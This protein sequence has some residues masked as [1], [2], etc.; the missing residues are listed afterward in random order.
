MFSIDRFSRAITDYAWLVIIATLALSFLATYGITKLR[1]TNDYR[2][3]F[4]DKN[5]YLEAFEELERTYSS[6]DTILFVY[7]PN[8]GKATS[9]EALRLA[10]DI[11]EASWQIPYS[12]RVDSV[13]N[14]QNTRAIGM[15]DLEVRAIVPYKED[16]NPESSIYAEDTI[17]GEP[18]LAGRLLSKDARTAAVIV[19]ATPPRDDATATTHIVE[20]AR[21]IKAEM[22]EKY[23]DFRIELTGSQL[24]SNSFSEA[25]RRDITVLLPIVFLII[26]AILFLTTRSISGTF[27][28]L[29]IILLSVGIAMGAAGWIGIPFSPPMGGVSTIVITIAV[30][31]CV[32]VLVLSLVTQN[33]GASKIEAIIESLKINA[34]P[35]FLTSITTAIGM[36]S[37][38]FSDAP[39]YQ[40]LGTTS[41]IG[42]MAAWVLTMTLF[43]ALLKVLP[44]KANKIIADQNHIMDKIANWVIDKYKILL[45]SMLA[46]VVVSAAAIPRLT[47]ND[48]FVDYFDESVDF[49]KA[50]DWAADN[51]TGIYLLNYSMPAGDA[52]GIAKPDYLQNL[53]KLATWMEAQPETAHVMSFASVIKRLNRSMHGDDQAYYRVPDNRELAAQ[54]LL[55]YEMSLPYGLDLND[56]INVDRSATRLIV[57]LH[58]IDVQSIKN[59]R[60]RA[61]QWMRDNLPAYMTA[62]PSG[63]RVDSSGQAVM[64]AFIGERNF[65]AMLNGTI[66]AFVLIS[67][68]LI[69]ALRSLRLG[70]V[71]L[72]P[73][74]APP[75]VAFGVFALIQ[76]EVG[77]WTSFV[78]A[79][80]IGIIVD[81]TVHILSKY[82]HARLDLNQ[83]C[84]DAIRYSFSTVGTA[85]WVSTLV[86]I[87]GF[88]ALSTSPFLVNAMLGLLVAGTI[89]A[90]L[91][92]DFLLLPPLLM[93]I[94]NRKLKNT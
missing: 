15:D 73:N 51:L 83:A 92:L 74:M 16:I 39:P 17:L 50:S 69:I 82:R 49:R 12:I 3:F 58:D 27:A 4:T 28:T 79:T 41:A 46:I 52:N 8:E 86:L 29:I 40:D 22:Q 43:P 84:T 42:A 68:C 20:H 63:E 10:Y 47:F 19:S 75:L 7:Q 72:I 91:V 61:Q 31:D 71:S 57:T 94:D 11:T 81:A 67:F 25:S 26:A 18:I 35:V 78:T 66:I 59:F 56:Q 1:L 93:L 2:Y 6:P 89:F 85:L 88:F 62:T 38:R 53:D 37:L 70:L 77:F 64:F 5:P 60:I 80:A 36:L 55:L 21:K 65:Y 23:P 87:I 24:L 30:A 9:P 44:M 34:Q 48:R 76:T 54:Y 45:V 90:A 33:K 14:F 32:H 13:T